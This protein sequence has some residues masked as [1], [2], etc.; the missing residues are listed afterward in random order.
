M[1]T[2]GT[3]MKFK[4]AK[5]LVVD[6]VEKIAQADLPPMF[7]SCAEV[8]TEVKEDVVLTAAKD[9][10]KD[11]AAICEI[12]DAP[13]DAVAD[14]FE[15]T[16]K[17]FAPASAAYKGIAKSLEMPGSAFQLPEFDKRDKKHHLLRMKRF[18]RIRSALRILTAKPPV[19]AEK[20][21]AL[22]NK[23]SNLNL[24]YPEHLLSLLIKV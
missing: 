2:V 5:A 7:V 16:W 17:Q 22:H 14:A 20:L 4:D 8:L 15:N 24:D 11:A 1:D 23:I 10:T 18:V 19:P 12:A 6:W 13:G 21:K 3:I 9:T